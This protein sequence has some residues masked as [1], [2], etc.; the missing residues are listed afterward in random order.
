MQGM[1]P[2]QEIRQRHRFRQDNPS[3]VSVVVHLCVAPLI[4]GTTI[5]YVSRLDMKHHRNADTDIMSRLVYLWTIQS[6]RFPTIILFEE[7]KEV[8]RFS[9]ARP[10]GFI[11]EFIEM[12]SRLLEL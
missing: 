1:L 12:N 2:S 10:A 6:T 7:G 9:S 8:E 4:K 5:D 3:G 11:R